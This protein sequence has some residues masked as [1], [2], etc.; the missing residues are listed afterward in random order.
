MDINFI[1]MQ[2]PILIDA[3]CLTLKISF[4]SIC[5]AT[6]LGIVGAIISYYK[7]KIIYPIIKIYIEISRNTPLLVQL[8]F[9]Y[10]GLPKLGVVLS[11]EQ[12]AIIGLV[13]LGGSY[14]IETLRA[15]LEAIEKSQIESAVSLGL[16]K[17][18]VMKYIILPQAI[19]ISM[20]TITANFIFLIK[21]TSI[22]GVVALPELVNTTYNLISIYY[23]TTEMLLL[24]TLSYLLIISPVSIISTLIERRL[25]NGEFTS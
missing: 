11:G 24:L 21:E 9:L 18:Q 22:V 15:G 10:F 4:L 23:K 7:V 8:F 6:I 16:N 17:I 14:M 2:I 12:C 19:R 3:I 1:E 25:K 13:F 20:P 5:G